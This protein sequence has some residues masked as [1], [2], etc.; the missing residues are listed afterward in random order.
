MTGQNNPAPRANAGSRADSKTERNNDKRSAI[1]L[2]ADAAAVWLA[3]R[4]PMPAALARVL[5]TL[6]SFGRAF[7]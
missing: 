3:A 5:A 4:F 7:R 2:N 1:D 6:A